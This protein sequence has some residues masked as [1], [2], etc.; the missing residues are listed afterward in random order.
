MP[1]NYAQAFWPGI[2]SY[3]SLSITDVSGI[4]P[5][6]A[7]LNCFPQYGIPDIEGDLVLTYNDAVIRWQ[8]CIIDSFSVKKDS[9]GRTVAVRIYDERWKW[10]YGQITG[11]Y[12]LRLPNNFVDPNHEA[13]PQDLASLLFSKMGV[14]NYDVSQLPNDA[15]PDCDWFC[16]NPAE[17]L[18]KICDDLGCRIV[19]QRSTGAYVI[20]VTG[21]GNDLPE[22]YPYKDPFDGLDPKEV[23]D[24]L[25][26]VTAPVNFQVSLKLKACGKDTD[27][28]WRDLDQLSYCPTPNSLI[29]DAYGF[30]YDYVTMCGKDS[31]H[32]ISPTR[33][34]QG[35]GTKISPREL[36][37]QTVF[38]C[39]RIDDSPD[40]TLLNPPGAGPRGVNGDYA[41]FLP[42]YGDNVTRKQ[43]IL[44][45]HL[46]QSWTDYRGEIH[47]RPSY[48]WGE[49]EVQKGATTIGQPFP[50]NYPQGTRIDYQ[51]AIYRESPEEP[52]SFSVSLDPIDTD[53]SIIQTS[54]QMRFANYVDD[55]AG[56][57]KE[58]PVADPAKLFYCCA[59]QVRDPITWQPT[60]YYRT[61][62]V[63]NGNDETHVWT[64]VKSD[65]QPW[66]ITL[67]NSDG[68]VSSTSDNFDE[69]NYQCD[70][71]LD[72]IQS[73]L[74]TI[75]TGTR[76]YIGIFPIDMD[77][78]IQQVSYRIG[79][80]G[81]DTVVSKGTE[82]DFDLPQY[83]ERRQRD[84]R[85]DMAGK[86]GLLKEI[87]ERARRLQ[88]TFN[89]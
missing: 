38:K 39:W 10:K 57:P 68:S 46:V 56:G 53:K 14:T 71:Y 42:G 41:F 81:A 65:I 63:G 6:I 16:A 34:D 69:V 31:S 13:T 64:I 72:Q 17:E 82:H 77:G 54:K 8:N 45:D 83:A 70:Y 24:Y 88:G 33:Q 32:M 27:Q 3:E 66:K 29:T 74:E 62:Q 40:S 36:A 89:T 9:G 4:N 1:Q 85:R 78:S 87:Q 5:S 61:R 11:R 84:G 44:T 23:P 28:S 47:Q 18:A 22:N 43:L 55:P 80:Q 60:A 48:I 25:Q 21:N 50:Y 15:R 59:V 35:D 20:C 75:I 2:I 49:F 73:T 19:P 86:L 26:V 51:G 79:K 30:G 58:V 37:L 12:N 7:I 67:Y 52:A 76:C